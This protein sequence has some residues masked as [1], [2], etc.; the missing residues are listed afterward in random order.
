MFNF[1]AVPSHH[2]LLECNLNATEML[3]GTPDDENIRL[4]F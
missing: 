2:A 1:S 4:G 3:L